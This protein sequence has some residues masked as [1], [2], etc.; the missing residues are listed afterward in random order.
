MKNNINI[1]NNIFKILNHNITNINEL[2]S[3]KISQ[4]ILKNKSIIIK[5]NNLIPVIKHNNIN[6]KTDKLTCMHSN[7]LNKQKFPGVNFLRQILKQN[8][9]KLKSNII[10]KNYSNKRKQYDIYYTIEPIQNIKL[11]KPLTSFQFN[12]LYKLHC[13]NNNYNNSYKLIKPIN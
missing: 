5:F 12:K 8:N 6:Y 4:E 10:T 7:S 3:I 2:Y 1:I 9:L 13:K 11:I